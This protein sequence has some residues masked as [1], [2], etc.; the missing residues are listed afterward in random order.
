MTIDD[1]IRNERLQYYISREAEK[2]LT[3]YH[4]T[5]LINMHILQVKKHYLLT[6]IE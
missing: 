4:L 5:K 1:N 2:I 6:K 3:L